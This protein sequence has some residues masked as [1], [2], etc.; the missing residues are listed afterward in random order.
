MKHHESTGA[1]HGHR[2]L[3][4]QLQASGF[5]GSEHKAVLAMIPGA[6][7]DESAEIHADYTLIQT[8]STWMMTG[9]HKHVCKFRVLFGDS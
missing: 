4:I 7:M 8:Y 5:A 2:K 6:T 1:K 9:D 3:R